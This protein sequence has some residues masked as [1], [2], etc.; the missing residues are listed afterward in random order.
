MEIK[1]SALREDMANQSNT[2]GY[3]DIQNSMP[4]QGFRSLENKEYHSSIVNQFCYSKDERS[5]SQGRSNSSNVQT[6]ARGSLDRREGSTL[7][8]MS[9]FKVII[10]HSMIVYFIKK[11][12]LTTT[13]VKNEDNI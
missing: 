6:N 4:D 13:I 8:R 11:L 9:N 5:K 7:G 1:A 12:L 10:P 2:L 3:R